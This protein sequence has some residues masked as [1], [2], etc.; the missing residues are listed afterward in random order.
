MRQIV[1]E[2]NALYKEVQSTLHEFDADKQDPQVEA[3]PDHPLPLS[4]LPPSHPPCFPA[5]ITLSKHSR[6]EQSCATIVVICAWNE[7]SFSLV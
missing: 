2:I 1:D 6:S 5:H 4:P 7:I 3:I